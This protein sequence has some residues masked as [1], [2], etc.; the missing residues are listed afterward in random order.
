VGKK[1]KINQLLTLSKPELDV[2][3]FFCTGTTNKKIS[4]ELFIVEGTVRGHMQNIY[5]KLALFGYPTT[6]RRFIV[7][8]DYCHLLC[9]PE[10]QQALEE[11]VRDIDKEGK[12]LI[13]IEPDDERDQDVDCNTSYP[14]GHIFI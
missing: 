8:K 11:G 13:V 5:I 1:E 3:K 9:D 2:L 12:A 4:K 7:I 6:K 14:A 10:F